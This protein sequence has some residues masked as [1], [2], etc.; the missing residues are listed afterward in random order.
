MST[1]TDA[2][3]HSLNHDSD[4]SAI[5]GII[6]G[7]GNQIAIGAPQCRRVSTT[8]GKSDLCGAAM[9]Q[10]SGVRCQVSGVRELR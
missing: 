2:Y 5:L 9:A 8:L 3:S 6:Q 10:F 1:E 4:F 7:I